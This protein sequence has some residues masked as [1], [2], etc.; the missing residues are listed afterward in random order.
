MKT[1]RTALSAIT[2]LLLLA[3]YVA[4]QLAALNGTASDYAERVDQAPIRYAALALLIA[5]IVLAF[6]REREP[7]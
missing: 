1:L 4:S 6:V 3:G 7:E 2:I 5:A